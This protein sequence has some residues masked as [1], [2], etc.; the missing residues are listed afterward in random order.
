MNDCPCCAPPWAF[1]KILESAYATVKCYSRAGQLLWIGDQKKDSGGVAVDSDGN[2]YTTITA[3]YQGT[4]YVNLRIVEK[5]DSSGFLLASVP[6]EKLSAPEIGV[7]HFKTT[8]ARAIS[9]SEA[10]VYII[11]MTTGDNG[12]SFAYRVD[13]W[14]HD[15]TTSATL[16]QTNGSTSFTSSLS[17]LKIAARG[18][19]VAAAAGATNTVTVAAW[20]NDTLNNVITS[21]ALGS[22]GGVSGLEIDALSQIHTSRLAGSNSYLIWSSS[23]TVTSATGSTLIS[24]IGLTSFSVP[25]LH[26]PSTPITGITNKGGVINAATDRFG[27]NDSGE[28]V[29][30]ISGSNPSYG[31]YDALDTQLWTDQWGNSS[32]DH[33]E[34]VVVTADRVYICGKRVLLT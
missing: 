26:N 23:P 1:A 21:S 12:T 31:Y 33:F 13:K 19:L 20:T 7:G 11:R 27:A 34:E 28:Y 17:L 10:G 3:G 24:A 22:S 14:D 29:K 25:G 4:D 5:R 15:L 32:G 2:T 8:G 18:T 6:M 16:P 9:V 30:S